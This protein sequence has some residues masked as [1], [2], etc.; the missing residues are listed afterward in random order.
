MVK[1]FNFIV[2]IYLLEVMFYSRLIL[3]GRK[4]WFC[5]GVSICCFLDESLFKGYY[6]I[7]VVLLI[8][9]IFFIFINFRLIIFFI[10][11]NCDYIVYI[12]ILNIKVGNLC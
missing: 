4:V 11:N 12:S 8:I 3:I 1:G 9:I 10:K 5:V 7:D 6:L 2:Y